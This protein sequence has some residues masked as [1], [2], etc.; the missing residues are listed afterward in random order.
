MALLVS[1]FNI[2]LKLV[3]KYFLGQLNNKKFSW[4]ITLSFDFLLV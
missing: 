3:K 2:K 4:S 1:F